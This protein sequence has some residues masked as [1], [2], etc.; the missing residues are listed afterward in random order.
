VA[1]N[2]DL[3]LATAGA[4][5]V[6]GLA[7]V[8]TATRSM[9]VQFGRAKSRNREVDPEG[10]GRAERFLNRL[11]LIGLAGVMI[12]SLGM[13][14]AMVSIATQNDFFPPRVAAMFMAVDAMLVPA[15]LLY[16]Q[17]LAATGVT[18]PIDE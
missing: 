1:Y 10:A 17:G 15:Q 4:A 6:L 2:S 11:Y 7:F 14:V 18:F 16:S 12:S 8:V 9:Q 3:W 5:P 13:A